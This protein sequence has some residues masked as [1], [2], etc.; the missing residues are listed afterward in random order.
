M[1][2]FCVGVQISEDDDLPSHG[3]PNCCHEVTVAYQLI[4]RCRQS[5]AELRAHLIDTQDLESAGKSSFAWHEEEGEM[6]TFVK[7]EPLDPLDIDDCLNFAA[8]GGEDD[9]VA[10]HCK[11]DEGSTEEGAYIYEYLEDE[12]ENQQLEEVA[13][14]ANEYDPTQDRYSRVHFCCAWECV[15][16]FA[17]KAELKE[18]FNVHL[19]AAKAKDHSPSDTSEQCADCRQSFATPEAALIHAKQLQL[20]KC[21]LSNRGYSWTKPQLLTMFNAPTKKCCGCN[22]LFPT[23]EALLVHSEREHAGREKAPDPDRPEQ[24]EICY[25]WFRFKK[26]VR[27][28]QQEVYKPPKRCTNDRSICRRRSTTQSRLNAHHKKRHK[29]KLAYTCQYCEKDFLI[30]RD[31]RQHE[32]THTGT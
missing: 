1:I 26:N 11:P 7:M 29:Q 23:L 17:T 22:K 16:K 25:K 21:I 2:L 19:L 24:C 13:P 15:Q 9:L 3:C 10:V 4:K 18:H 30:Y 14:I 27:I 5:D 31:W 12:M 8:N 20:K 6:E 32:A 28:H